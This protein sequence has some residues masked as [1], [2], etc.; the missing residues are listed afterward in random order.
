MP[1]L[2]LIS[3]NQE[4]DRSRNLFLKSPDLIQKTLT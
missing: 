3:E 2:H 1:A 4:Q